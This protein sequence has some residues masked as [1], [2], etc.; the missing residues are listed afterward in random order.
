MGSPHVDRLEIYPSRRELNPLTVADVMDTSGKHAR[1][2]LVR[3]RP[4]QHREQTL[5]TRQGL[6]WLGHRWQ[7][8]LA[9]DAREVE[10]AKIQGDLDL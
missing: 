5:V 10:R 6:V 2:R 7:A 4:G 3:T 8:K 1:V 9:R